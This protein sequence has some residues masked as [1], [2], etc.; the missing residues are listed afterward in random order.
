MKKIIMMAVM[1]VAAISASAQ[2]YVG[3]NVN[4][5]VSD[6]KVGDAES[7]STTAFSINPEIGYNFNETW[8]AGVAVGFGTTKAGDAK[9][10]NTVGVSPYVRCKFVQG[11]P[12]G[13]FADAFFAYENKS[14]DGNSTNG[15]AVGLRPG[16]S[17]KV[18]DKV[19]LT[20]TTTLFQYGQAGKDPLKVKTT[21][22]QFAPSNVALGVYYNF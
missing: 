20:A 17:V 2:V 13:V 4:F 18:S 15:W 11:A 5:G 9:A 16:L 22:F 21:T 1:A 7:T 6:V 8:A 3:G 19:S 12:V 14:C 10:V